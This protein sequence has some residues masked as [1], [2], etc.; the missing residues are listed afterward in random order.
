MMSKSSGV[1]VAPA[2]AV[3]FLIKL[4]KTKTE[5]KA[6][7]QQFGAFLAV[8]APLGLWWTVYCKLRFGVPVGALTALTP[9]NPQYIGGFSIS[10]RFFGIDWQHLSV[11]ENWDWQNHVFEYNLLFAL[12]K[13]S[14]FDEAKALYRRSRPVL[15][16]DIVLE[17]L[18]ADCRLIG[19]YGSNRCIC[20]ARQR[21]HTV[22]TEKVSASK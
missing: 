16:A 6:L 2:V 10:Q 4:L 9:D 19:L 17:Q 13:T 21:N 7:W 3:V 22:A 1:L 14:L 15:R 18:A 8:C 11:F 20:G 5:R 12:L